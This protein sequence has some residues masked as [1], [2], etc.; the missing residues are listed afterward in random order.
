MRMPHHVDQWQRCGAAQEAQRRDLARRI[1]IAGS[2]TSLDPDLW[3]VIERFWAL[4]I[5][6]IGSCAGHLYPTANGAQRSQLFVTVNFLMGAGPRRRWRRFVQAVVTQRPVAGAMIQVSATSVSAEFSNHAGRQWSLEAKAQHVLDNLCSA[7]NVAGLS[8]LAAGARWDPWDGPAPDVPDAVRLEPLNSMEYVSYKHGQA[9]AVSSVVD[10]RIR[11]LS[12]DTIARRTSCS[13]VEARRR[14]DVYWAEWIARQDTATSRFPS[15][16]R[17]D[18]PLP[19]AVVQGRT[20]VGRPDVSAVSL[21]PAVSA[22]EGRS[23]R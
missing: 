1:T 22:G 5:P 9:R 16:G 10:A 17:Q 12:W 18:V 6:T 23:V 8:S 13:V 19:P 21:D 20:A 4:G 3:P 15:R 11:G 7:L 2:G 14:W